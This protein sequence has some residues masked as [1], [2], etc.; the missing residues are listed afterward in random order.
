[1]ATSV[2]S[3]AATF[4]A[5]AAGYVVGLNVNPTDPVVSVH[6]RV[7]PGPRGTLSWYLAQSGVQVLPNR[8]GGPVVADGEWDTWQL[9]DF[10]QSGAWSC[11]GTNTG[12]N[13]HTVYL[14]FSHQ[15]AAAG[16]APGG[17]DVLTGFPTFDADLAAMWL[18]ASGQILA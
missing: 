6:W 1:M 4:P 15:V 12:S 14:E 10:P 17:G 9:N 11:V 18:D 5:G 3:F 16:P 2:S 13:A 7:P 8:F